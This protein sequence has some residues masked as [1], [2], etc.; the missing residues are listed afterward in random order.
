MYCLELW[1]KQSGA[2]CYLTDLN[3]VPISLCLVYYRSAYDRNGFSNNIIIISS[4]RQIILLM[5]TATCRRLL[6]PEFPSVSGPGAVLQAS[7]QW[8]STI[9]VLQYDAYKGRQEPWLDRLKLNTVSLGSGTVCIV[10]YKPFIVCTPVVTY[11][12]LLVTVRL[13]SITNWQVGG[14]ETKK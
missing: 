6:R 7:Q 4:N 13:N 9:Y 8:S 12:P 10:I 3:E 11:T 1:P 5:S 14:W 2:T